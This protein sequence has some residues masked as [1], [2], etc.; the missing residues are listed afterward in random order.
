MVISPKKSNV[1]AIYQNR[2]AEAILI[3]SHNILFDGELLVI[4]KK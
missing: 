3:D 2:L 1:V 4:V